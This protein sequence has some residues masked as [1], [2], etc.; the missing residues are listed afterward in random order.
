M[1]AG[2]ARVKVV[3]IGDVHTGRIALYLDEQA[4]ID[5][6]WLYGPRDGFFDEIMLA[7]EE[8]YPP[9]SDDDYR[10][11]IAFVIRPDGAPGFEVT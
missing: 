5:L 10:P 1:H 8:A 11:G 3:K 7:V 4:A 9:P 2:N 6:A